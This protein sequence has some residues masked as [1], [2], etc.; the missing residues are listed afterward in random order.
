VKEFLVAYLNEKPKD[1]GVVPFFFFCLL[2]HL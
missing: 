1:V 2:K